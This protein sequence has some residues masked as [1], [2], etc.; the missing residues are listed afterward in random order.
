MKGET[1]YYKILGV[2]E[3]ASNH[4]LRKAFC[5]LS[6]ELHPDTT[7]LEINVAKSKFQEVLEAYE[8]LNNSNLRKIYDDKL[9]ENSRSTNNTNVLNN[10]VID[11]NN[12]NLL[13]N[14]RPFS[15]GE[16]FSLFLLII[17]ISISLI[18]SIFI[19]SFTGKELETIPLWLIK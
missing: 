18:C 6:I 3:N 13:G 2:N 5:K 14:R 7:S 11:S 19:A 17:I 8:H 10:L 9:K 12:Q 16:L 4:E 15:N 1:S